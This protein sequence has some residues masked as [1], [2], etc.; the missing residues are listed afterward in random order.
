MDTWDEFLRWPT[1]SALLTAEGTIHSL[2]A[3]MAATL[4]RQ[5]KQCEGYDF[6]SLLPETQRP[7]AE[8]LLIH[9]ATT[10]TVAMRVLEF[11]RPGKA[12]VVSL[13]EARPVKD[14]ASRE[15]LVWVHAVDARNDPGGLLVPFRLA[16]AAADL[17][18]WMFTP[19]SQRLDWL[20]GAPALA[21]LFPHASTSLIRVF[22]R[23][24]PDDRAALEQLAH[25]RAAQS[26]W[27]SLRFRT[28]NDGWH[29]M[30]CQIRRIQ[31]GYGGT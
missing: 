25:S 21:A 20:D 30:A 12:S 11:S 6:L 31:L 7:S 10:T 8:S 27:T 4:G 3:P 29:H 19:R 1:P 14:P 5:A 26:P 22:R 2:N 17:G 18:L 16:A 23:V 24:H 15:R 28:E 13:I 9:G